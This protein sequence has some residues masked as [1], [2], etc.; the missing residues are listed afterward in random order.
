MPSFLLVLVAGPG[1][2]VEETRAREAVAT[3][4]SLLASG[5]AE[6]VEILLS[7]AGADWLGEL[8]RQSPVA[9]PLREAMA[10]GV[11]LKVCTRAAV[12]RGGLEGFDAVPEAVAAGAPTLIASR[13]Q[14]GWSLLSY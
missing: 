7:G 6:E 13:A 8:A 1:S 9:E 11:V 4:H 14:A 5:M 12:E 3:A 2:E 10:A